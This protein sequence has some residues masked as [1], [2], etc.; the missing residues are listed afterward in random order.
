M[1]GHETTAITGKLSRDP[2]MKYTAAGLAVTNFSIPVDRKVGE[3]RKTAWWNI[4]V[5]GKA[6]ESAKTNLHKGS[7]V[8]VEGLINLDKE[9]M[10][11]AVYEKD[12]VHKSS[13][14]LNANVL[15]YIDNFGNVE[16]TEKVDA[17]TQDEI[18]F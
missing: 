6:A 8:R 12:G 1:S 7:V 4:N 13:L 16:K 3:E 9:T 17:A 5:Y 14:K 11:P 15:S 18:P 10:C 2:E